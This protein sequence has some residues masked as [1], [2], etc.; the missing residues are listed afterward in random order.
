MKDKGYAGI[1]YFR[2][3]A[4]VM[5]IAIHTYPLASYHENAEFL[6]THVFCRLAVPFFFLTSGFFLFRNG[7]RDG[8]VLGRYLKKILFLYGISVVLYLPVNVYM[9]YFKQPHYCRTCCGI[10]SGT[11]RFTISGIFRRL[12]LGRVSHGFVSDICARERRY[13]LRRRCICSDCSETAT[14]DLRRN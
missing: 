12:R 2:I 7:V 6:F 8:A 13:L 4:A 1:D 10:C 9:G 11:E 14:M 5:V 3:A